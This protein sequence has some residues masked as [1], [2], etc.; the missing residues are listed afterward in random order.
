MMMSMMTLTFINSIGNGLNC[1]VII[2]RLIFHG[3]KDHKN[4][5]NL[6]KISTLMVLYAMALKNPHVLLNKVV[7]SRSCEF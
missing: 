5:E 4:H 1:W 7:C 6:Y 3:L 2:I